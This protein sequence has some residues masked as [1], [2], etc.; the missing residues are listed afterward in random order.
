MAVRIN[1]AIF[2][3]GILVIVFLFFYN[4]INNVQKNII[5][6]NNFGSVIVYNRVLLKE[7]IFFITAFL[8]S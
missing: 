4:R 5:S 8:D 7:I 6:K 3:I 2:N 1:L